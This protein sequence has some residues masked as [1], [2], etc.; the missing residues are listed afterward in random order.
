[1]RN[2]LT[3]LGRNK[4]KSIKVARVKQIT[5]YNIECISRRPKVT[6]RKREEEKRN[7]PRRPPGPIFSKPPPEGWLNLGWWLRQRN[8]HTKTHHN[9]GGTHQ[10]QTQKHKTKQPPRGEGRGVP[11]GQLTRLLLT[12]SHVSLVQKTHTSTRLWTRDKTNK[13]GSEVGEEKDRHWEHY[14]AAQVNNLKITIEK[15]ETRKRYN[16]TLHSSKKL[17]HLQPCRGRSCRQSM[18]TRY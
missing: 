2:K 3:R 9:R 8:T 7:K 4:V 18:S 13:K 11:K 17:K 1:M 5:A 16:R 15:K 14:L 10:H 6:P 12:Q